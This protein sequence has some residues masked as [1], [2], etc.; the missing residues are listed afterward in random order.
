MMINLTQHPATS[1][2][3]N[4]GVV[5]LDDANRE[6]LQK[7][8]TFKDLPNAGE[9]YSRAA[10]IADLAWDTG[11]RKAMIEG[12]SFLMSAL[13]TALK[14]RDITPCYAFSESVVEMD[15]DGGIYK[16]SVFER[17]GFVEV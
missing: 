4:A 10:K 3:I 11:A 1:E 17:L 8:L 14:E 7:L 16:I 5:D 9:I 2:Q 13:E 12:P 15:K 6:T